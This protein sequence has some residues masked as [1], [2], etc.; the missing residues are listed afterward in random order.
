MQEKVVGIEAVTP[1]RASGWYNRRKLCEAIRHEL[2]PGARRALAAVLICV[3]TFVLFRL[4][5]DW[6]TPPHTPCPPPRPPRHTPGW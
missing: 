4:L 6:M 2:E 3:L 1:R 5:V